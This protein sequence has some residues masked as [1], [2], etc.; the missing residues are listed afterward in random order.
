MFYYYILE[1]LIVSDMKGP[2]D[3]FLVNP[4]LLGRVVKMCDAFLVENATL[5]PLQLQVVF[6]FLFQ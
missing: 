2:M 1:N 5:T 3:F 6:N 4:D